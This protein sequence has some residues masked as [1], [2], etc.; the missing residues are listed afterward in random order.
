MTQTISKVEQ[1]EAERKWVLFWRQHPT[2]NNQANRNIMESYL[3][4]NLLSVASE[5]GQEVLE[6]AFLACHSRLS[7]RVKEREP[8]KPLPPPKNDADEPFIIKNAEGKRTFNPFWSK[9][10]LRA[11]INQETR[12][13]EQPVPVLPP[14][15]NAKRLKQMSASE[16]RKLAH[17]TAFTAG[18]GANSDRLGME[19]INNRLQ[20]NN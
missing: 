2:F 20:G 19:A 1:A 14:E 18:L 9:E 11:A 12:I 17:D 7:E 5:N 6:I 16:L 15:Y 3:D 13:V 8:S 4:A 10:R